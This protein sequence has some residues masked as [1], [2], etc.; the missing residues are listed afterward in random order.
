MYRPLTADKAQRRVLI[1]GIDGGTWRVLTPAIEQG[2]MPFLRHLIN[3]GA[4]GT[5]LSTIPALT[6]PAWASFQTGR[7]PGAT[8]IFCFSS[9]DRKA[10]KMGFVSAASLRDTIWEQASQA[11]K[12]VVVLNVPL[13]W[14]PRPV[15]G[16]MV[17]GLM[18]PSMKSEFTWP[19][20]LKDELLKVVPDYQ[21][22]KAEN[23]KGLPA[24][25]DMENVIGHMSAALVNRARAAEHLIFTRSPD[26]CMV[27]FQSS[28]LIQHGLW[29]YLDPKDP[30]YDEDKNMYIF[31]HFYGALDKA[32]KDTCE[33]FS[34]S[35]A[36]NIVTFVISDHGFEMHRKRF[37]LGTWL[38]QQGLLQRGQNLVKPPWYKR[39]TRAL[40]VG[41]MLRFLMSNESVEKLES[42]L[43]FAP[44]MIEWDKSATYATGYSSE[45]GI[46][47]LQEDAPH[48]VNTIARI[49]KGLKALKDPFTSAPIID[50]IYR[51]EELYRGPLMHLMPDLIVVPASG[52]TCTGTC[53]PD[54]PV[55]EDVDSDTDPHLG[56]HHPEGIIVA[57]GSGIAE[58][59]GIQ[60]GIIDAAPTIL[61]CLGLDLRD[62]CDGN[63]I[64]E[65]FTE[66]FLSQRGQPRKGQPKTE[67]PENINTQAHSVEDEAEIQK[68]LRELGYM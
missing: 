14:P 27:H 19:P 8:G 1:I 32:M 56:K 31:E 29:C 67:G 6:P 57:C 63:V 52:I 49:T 51:K 10:R 22:F 18:T 48:R 28:D 41:R 37:N 68:K 13:T 11:G 34:R 25:K 61:Y 3:N 33:A 20:E 54:R 2:Y 38:Y 30:L 12:R 58:K 53:L 60:A 24:H 64:T 16:V 4:S 59:I 45:A 23:P 62:D 21:L 9:F 5:L 36:G 43:N 42:A 15:N 40:R 66:E 50:A 55:L 47:I 44:Q 65:L 39:V 46:Y 17:T 7:N 35:A 26:L